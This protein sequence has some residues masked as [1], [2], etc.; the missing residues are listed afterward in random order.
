MGL[1]ETTQLTY[2]ELTVGSSAVSARLCVGDHLP[3]YTTRE[4]ATIGVGIFGGSRC[5]S[6]QA[7]SWTSVEPTSSVLGSRY[8]RIR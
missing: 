4:S 3:A 1:A 7:D 8:E 5:S 6:P 2:P